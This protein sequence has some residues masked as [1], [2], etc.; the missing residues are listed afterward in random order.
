MTLS[1]TGDRRY[2]EDG[3]RVSREA[4]LVDTREEDMPERRGT[5]DEHRH[6][7]NHDFNQQF[8][9]DK[10]TIDRRASQ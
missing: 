2:Q 10:R 4:R 7:R 8:P 9:T 6:C 5:I 3:W 1:V